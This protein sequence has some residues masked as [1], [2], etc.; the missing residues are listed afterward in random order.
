MHPE[1]KIVTRGNR[2]RR[3]NARELAKIN[4]AALPERRSYSDRCWI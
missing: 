1:P 3:F 2:T 4:V